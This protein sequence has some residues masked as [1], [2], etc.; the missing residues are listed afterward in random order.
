MDILIVLVPVFVIA[1][2]FLTVYFVGKE[3]R[4][5]QKPDDNNQIIQQNLPL[6]SAYQ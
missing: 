5:T 3:I 4:K 1:G 6:D 2:V